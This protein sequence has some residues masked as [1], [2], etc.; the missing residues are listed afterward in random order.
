MT[1]SKISNSKFFISPD[2]KIS[3][4]FSQFRVVGINCLIVVKRSKFLGTITDGD[5]RKALLKDGNMRTSIENIYQKNAFSI[6]AEDVNNSQKIKKAF[7]KNHFSLIPV[8]N[9]NNNVVKIITWFDFFGKK[10]LIKKFEAPM[11]I[12][13]GGKGTRMAPFTNVLPKP[14][15]PIN[16]QTVIERIIN[17]FHKHGKNDIYI[18]INFKGAILKA[19]F[20]ELTPS[21][22]VSFIEE[23]KPLGTAGALSKLNRKLRKSFFLTNCDVLFDIDY[24]DVLDHHRKSKSIIT[25]VASAKEITI[26]YGSLQ[27][28]KNGYLSNFKEKPVLDYLIN[29]GLYIIHPDALSYI[30]NDKYFD[31]TDL[32][33]VLLNDNH[34]IGVYPINDDQWVDVGQWEEYR[35]AVSKIT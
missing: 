9:S 1:L 5:I 29:C 7:I 2:S 19:Y 30:P 14:L 31:I 4:A 34:K 21:Y 12:M 15:I 13:A 24:K 11:I 16:N 17:S 27:I 6:Y 33:A 3:D 35:K 10:E 32:I 23:S 25:L 28:S 20:Q 22:S 26:P 18:S 8:I